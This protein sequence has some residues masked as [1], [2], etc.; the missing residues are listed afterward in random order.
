MHLDE[1]NTTLAI[2]VSGI[3]LVY[4]EINARNN[5]CAINSTGRGSSAVILKES[6]AL[7][8]GH[9]QST[10]VL[11]YIGYFQAG[12]KIF[13]H[14]IEPLPSLI[15]GRFYVSYLNGLM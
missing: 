15:R 10:H 3:Y 5:L 11:L 12:Q 13:L 4:S 8:P 7:G 9:I 6:T 1:E 2:E 14:Y